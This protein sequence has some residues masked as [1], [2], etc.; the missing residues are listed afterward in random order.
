[1]PDVVIVGAGITGLSAARVLADA[2][3]D[4]VVLER[5]ARAG[6]KAVS[7]RFGGFLMEH[8]PSTVN[9]SVAAAEDTVSALGLA[10]SRIELGPRVRRRYLYDDGRLSGIALHPLGFFLSPYLPLAARLSMLAEPIRRARATGSDESVF[11]FTARRFGRGFAESVMDPMVGGIFMGNSREL[12]VASVFPRLVAL[13][14][15]HGSVVRGMVRSRREGDP[16]RRLCSWPGGVGTLP[17]ALTASLPKPP[18]TGV[19]V[20][21]IRRGATGFT[22]ETSAGDLHARAVLVTVQPHVAAG[23][24][25][26]LDPD[27]AVAAGE[28]PAPAAAVV[29]AGYPRAGVAHPLD[30]LGYLATRGSGDISGVQ[31]CSTMFSGRAP[32]GHVAIAAYV[33]GDRGRLLA[34]SPA[35]D[36]KAEVHRQL[37]AVLGISA[38]PVVS[39]VRHWSLGLPQYLLGHAARRDVLESTCGRVAGLFLAGNYLRGVSVG[40]CIDSGRNAA[41][42]IASYLEAAA[43]GSTSGS[44]AAL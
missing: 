23:L 1:M 32:E 41:E 3:L 28:I 24:L 20:I 18:K 11:A 42:R 36:L 40:C 21:R 27:G 26:R 7:E 22:V 13:E 5:T 33:G 8:G 19:A 15:A 25:D 37:A 12:S 16:G 10:G 4:A 17:N 29:F 39:R 31:F 38:M 30:G 43:S 2:G 14:R 34:Q 6:G 35:P 44:A 9:A